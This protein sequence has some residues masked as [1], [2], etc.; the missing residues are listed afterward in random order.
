[1]RARQPSES[2]C[3]RLRTQGLKAVSICATECLC[4]RFSVAIRSPEACKRCEASG[5]TPKR[6]PT[7]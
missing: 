5:D 4:M 7:L 6:M 3:L 1:M 2:G